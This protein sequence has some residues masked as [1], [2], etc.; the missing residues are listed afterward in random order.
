MTEGFLL[1]LGLVGR[2]VFMLNIPFGYWRDRSRK[3]SLQW[4][5]A[6]HLPIP[7]IIGLRIV[8]HLGWHPST[9]PVTIGSF[10]LGQFLGGRLHRCQMRKG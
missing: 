6:I 2:A 9:F 1:T 3:F 5:L 8:T 4:I 7:L 10:F